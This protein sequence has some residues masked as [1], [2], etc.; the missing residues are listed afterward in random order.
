MQYFPKRAAEKIINIVDWLW[1]DLKMRLWL[2]MCL[3]VFY[4]IDKLIWVNKLFES[5]QCLLLFLLKGFF[6][7]FFL[8]FIWLGRKWEFYCIYH[9]DTFY[10]TN[11]NVFTSQHSFGSIFPLFSYIQAHPCGHCACM[12]MES[13]FLSYLVS[14]L[15]LT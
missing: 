14:F 7:H 5:N 13:A 10:Q 4:F 9:Y 3:Y 6:A 2:W 15:P 8:T 11:R 1:Y 12:R